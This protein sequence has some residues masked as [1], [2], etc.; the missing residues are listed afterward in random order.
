MVAKSETKPGA[1]MSKRLVLRAASATAALFLAGSLFQAAPARANI[2]FD[3]SGVCAN[4]CGAT[5]SG[6][7]TLSNNYAFG[8]DLTAADF[9]SFEYSSS[10][11][12]FD[13]SSADSP[14]LS[15]GLNADGSFNSTGFMDVVSAAG[16]PFFD[17][18][19]IP[20]QFLAKVTEFGAPDFGSTFAFTLVT[21]AVPE[22]STW[23]MILIGFGG[24]GFAGWHGSRKTAARAA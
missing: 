19:L 16:F 14:V 20:V 12:S 23:T 3:F 11:F 17:S 6:R 8:S 13:I 15:G 7:L 5:A 10:S 1:G 21:G 22:P 4:S 24:L 9:I 2:V 18:G